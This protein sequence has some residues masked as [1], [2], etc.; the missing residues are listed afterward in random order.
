MKTRK[1]GRREKGR[2]MK[3]RKGGRRKTRK[4]DGGKFSLLRKRDGPYYPNI[5]SV[6]SKV[7]PF[8]SKV[9][10]F[11]RP[12]FSEFSSA[13]FSRNS[14]PSLFLAVFFTALLLLESLQKLLEMGGY[15]YYEINRYC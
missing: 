11:L 1:R 12:F 13:P 8:F 2:R 4:R 7:R 14:P 6:T 15:F 3:T 10:I 9:R 5:N